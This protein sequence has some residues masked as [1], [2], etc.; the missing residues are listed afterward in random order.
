MH[1]SKFFDLSPEQMDTLKAA[2]LSLFSNI[3]MCANKQSDWK[4]SID[5]CTKALEIDSANVKALFRRATAY[6]KTNKFEEALADLANAS[7]SAPEDKNV[8]KATKRVQKAQQKQK[9]KEKK[10]YGKMFS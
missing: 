7:Q 5:N 2:K 3:A 10:M 1:C 4:L 9:D 8:A 6:E